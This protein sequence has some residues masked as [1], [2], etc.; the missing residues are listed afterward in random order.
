MSLAILPTNASFAIEY[1]YDNLNRLKQVNYSANHSITYSYDDA[2]NMLSAKSVDCTPIATHG[3]HPTT[4]EERDFT[5]PCDV[6]SDWT[7]GIAPDNDQDGVNDI[8]DNDDD[9]DGMPDVWEIVHQ[10]NPFVNDADDDTDGDGLTNLAEYANGVNSTNPNTDDIA[11]V[12]ADI[13][14]IAINAKGRKTAF[15]LTDFS[16]L[17]SDGKDGAVAPVVVSV[18]NKKALIKNHKLI[19]HSGK[20]DLLWQATDT[21]GNIATATQSVSVVPQV[22]LAQNQIGGEGVTL[23][24]EAFLTGD[25]PNYPV[26]IPFTI[27][28]KNIDNNDYKLLN[29][30]G[31]ILLQKQINITEKRKGSIKI[32]LLDDGQSEDLE[33]LT[34]RMAENIVNAKKG[35]KTTHSIKIITKNMAPRINSFIISQGGR[36]GNTVAKDGGNVE[37]TVNAFD[38]NGNSLNYAWSSSDNNFPLGAASL[39]SVNFNPVNLDAKVYPLKLV[40]NDGS[41]SSNRTTQIKVV[42]DSLSIKTDNDANGLADSEEQNYQGHELKIDDD[43]NMYTIGGIKIMVGTMEMGKAKLSKEEIIAYREQNNLSIYQ[44]DKFNAT[45]IYDYTIENIGEVGGNA[46]IVIGLSSAVSK[47]T[48]LRKYN[49]NDN[50]WSDFQ[51]NENNKIYSKVDE[52][53]NNENWRAGLNEGATCLKLTIEDGG[54]NDADNTQNGSIDDPVATTTEIIATVLITNLQSNTTAKT[55]DNVIAKHFNINVSNGPVN[56]NQL[57]IK[58]S[59]SGNDKTQ[60]KEVGLLINDNK[61]EIKS[62]VYGADNGELVIEPVN[63]QIIPNGDTNIKIT[64]EFN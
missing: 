31:S 50:T 36:L 52:T 17:A 46:D 19:L 35:K 56:F 1:K 16:V 2:G 34:L 47:D 30:D 4:G 57:T 32:V 48:Y 5:S 24:I 3:Y 38:P 40:I 9:N 28:G 51:E 13:A 42:N 6:P 59:N 8:K 62:N 58:A 23:E 15:V 12:F 37:V 43:K 22:N 29:S 21:A 27:D 41:L 18:N 39:A 61:I 10:L 20:H 44:E 64:Y 14:D 53:C 63:V 45:Q 54:A 7:I 25:A 33:V 49:I 55:G 60:I 26:Q 11:P